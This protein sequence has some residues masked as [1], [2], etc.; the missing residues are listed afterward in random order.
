[1]LID[2][3]TDYEIYACLSSSCFV[4][5]K[6]TAVLP[7]TCTGREMCAVVF[8]TG[9]GRMATGVLELQEIA[10]YQIFESEA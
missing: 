10:L 1:L 2:G 7:K 4:I 6:T 3:F 5:S 9:L 8:C